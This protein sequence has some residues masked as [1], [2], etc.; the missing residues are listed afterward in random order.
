DKVKRSLCDN[1]D[2]RLN[3]LV[4][5]FVFFG[6]DAK[7]CY[8]CSTNPDTDGVPYDAACGDLNYDGNAE[9]YP[10]YV[11]CA[12][13]VYDDGNVLRLYEPKSSADNDDVCQ[14]YNYDDGAGDLM[15]CWCPEDKCNSHL[16]EE[17]FNTPTTTEQLPTEGRV[18]WLRG[19]V[20]DYG[21]WGPRFDSQSSQGLSCYNCVDCSTV[22]ENTTIVFDENFLTCVTI[23]TS[24]ET[25]I[26]SGG[27]EAYPDG[28][29]YT[30]GTVTYCHCTTSLC[31]GM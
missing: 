18:G 31:N 30:E 9:S 22:D 20:F 10:I 2:Y 13:I 15:R 8:F 1:M 25:I 28:E 6:A 17:C 26:R 21:C 11:G 4:I 19:S 14:R 16:C 23:M 27:F 12:I 5:L 7:I 29:C 24:H 3:L